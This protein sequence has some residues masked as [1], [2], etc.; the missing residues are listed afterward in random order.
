MSYYNSSDV[1]GFMFIAVVVVIL[2]TI[3][4]FAIFSVGKDAARN[5]TLCWRD[6][7]E[8]LHVGPAGDVSEGDT[9]IECTVER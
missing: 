1:G 3:I 8:V 6:K 2:L 5:D 9:I 4:S 7:K